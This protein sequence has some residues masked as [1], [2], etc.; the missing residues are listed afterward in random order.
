MLSRAFPI[1][2]LA[3]VLLCAEAQA[4]IYVH[5]EGLEGDV[6]EPG[7][8]GWIAVTAYNW[9]AERFGEGS[10]G[11][12]RQPGQVAIQDFEITLQADKATPKLLEASLRGEVIPKVEIHQTASYGGRAQT[13]LA[14]ELDN[15]LI[16]RYEVS[17][18]DDAGPPVIVLGHNFEEI[19]V[20]YTEFD[21]SGREMG[22]SEMRYNTY[23][24][25]SG[26][27]AAAVP[28]PSGLLLAAS[29]LS[30]L[31]FVSLRIR[32]TCPT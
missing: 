13:Y 12:A 3:T 2:L 23:D 17:G 20:T 7:Y 31:A 11:S 22:N 10:R 27:M 4:A 19:K 18:N 8:E 26:D 25:R 32:W 24:Q 21:D 16:N 5:Y 15:L 28:E 1:G 6:D 29:C 30:W 9:G 14:Y